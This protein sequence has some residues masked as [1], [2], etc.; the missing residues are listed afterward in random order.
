M[1]TE[2]VILGRNFS[3]GSVIAILT[4][5]S[6]FW[7]VPPE[8]SSSRSGSASA[9]I[10]ALTS[11]LMLTWVLGWMR[12]VAVTVWTIPGDHFWL[13]LKPSATRTTTS[14]TTA[15]RMMISFLE[16]RQFC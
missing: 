8:P 5:N 7:S 3:S 9:V 11:A 16:A 1:S 12:P 6:V 13:N 15:S 14:T 4:T 10:F 2:A